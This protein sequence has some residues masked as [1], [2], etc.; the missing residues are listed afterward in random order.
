MKVTQ[1]I[2]EAI[3][4]RVKAK[5]DEA[6]KSANLLLNVELERLA[7]ERKQQI[8]ALQEEYQKTFMAMLEKLDNK[9]ISYYYNTYNRKITS[10]EEL[11]DRNTPCVSIEL[12]SDYAEELKKKILDNET[13]AK[14]YINDIILE[15]ELG[16]TKPTL[17][18]LLNNITF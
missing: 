18:S 5:C 15:L 14:K 1:V 2:K 10:K 6:N 12:T 13:K 11:C 16:A 7:E 17:E 8:N 9:K 3:T 4:A